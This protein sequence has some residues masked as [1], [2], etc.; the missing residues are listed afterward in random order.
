MVLSR[1]QLTGDFH[2]GYS[3]QNPPSLAPPNANEGIVSLVKWS[4]LDENRVASVHDQTI[5]KIWDIRGGSPLMTLDGHYDKINS[6]DWS[7]T[8]ENEFFRHLPMEQ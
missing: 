5:I 2:H 1:L 3:L 4:P 7:L 8:N 6:I